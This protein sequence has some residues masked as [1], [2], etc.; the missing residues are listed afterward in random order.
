MKRARDDR[1]GSLDGEAAVDG[2][3]RGQ[4]G[5]HRAGCGIGQE[6]VDGGI[7]GKANVLDAHARARGNR[8]HGR[9][10][11]DGIAEEVHHVELG[12]LRRLVIGQIAHRERHHEVP[13]AQQLQHV[14][15]LSRLR[16]HALNGRNHQQRNVH[17]GGTLYHRAQVVRMPGHVNQADKLAAGKLE[18]AKAE[19]SGH[20]SAP[21]D[22]Q[23]VGIFA[24]QRLDK[25]RLS[26]VDVSCCSNDNGTLDKLKRGH[27][28]KPARTA[29]TNADAHRSRSVSR[30]SVRTSNSTWSCRTRVTTGVSGS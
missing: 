10:G 2:Q 11:K 9:I 17:A 16:H 27:Q 18:L 22:L 14:H 28:R 20:A 23:T 5:A 19:L 30:K 6:R 13:H 25:G 24:G 4:T 21:F 26:V 8:H 3:A 29:S 15:V 1:P 7:E 12:E